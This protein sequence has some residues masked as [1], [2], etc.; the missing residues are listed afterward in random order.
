MTTELTEQELNMQIASMVDQA[1]NLLVKDQETLSFA[2]RF[3]VELSKLRKKRVAW[4]KDLVDKAHQAHKA[5]TKRRSDALKPIDEADSVVR[6]LTGAYVAKEKEKQ[7]KKQEILDKK[8]E[9]QAA[10]KEAKLREKAE[11]EEDPEKK[12]ELEEKA[13]NVYVEPKI[14]TPTVEKTSRV[15]GGSVSFVTDIEVTVENIK[16]ICKGVGEGIIPE[17]VIEIK[18]S[19]LKQWAKLKR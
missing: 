18:E 12:A 7:R 13:E 6:S 17:N 9:E 16:Q 2:N 5:L 8:A 10:K 19:K 15:G 11:R 14:A 4:F 1:G 3:L